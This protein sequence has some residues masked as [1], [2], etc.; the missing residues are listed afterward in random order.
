MF[1]AQGGQLQGR[2]A[3]L[4]LCKQGS[5]ATLT[6]CTEMLSY[7][8]GL[9]KSLKNNKSHS[10]SRTEKEGRTAGRPAGLGTS[11]SDRVTVLNAPQGKGDKDSD[12]G[13]RSEDERAKPLG[14]Q[15]KTH[16]CVEALAELRTEQGPDG[17]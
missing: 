17:K 12:P 9:R 5:R 7:W 14:G 16:D 6:F 15:G 11:R 8:T 4:G 10:Y 13:T 1:P 2:G 3:H